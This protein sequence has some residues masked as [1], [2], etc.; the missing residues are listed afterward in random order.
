[1]PES[2]LLLLIWR[3]GRRG[4]DR[5]ATTQE[6]GMTDRTFVLVISAAV[7]IAFL[8]GAATVVIAAAI[9]GKL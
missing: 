4:G 6:T 2:G 9:G 8:A 3:T 7:A 5:E 1:M